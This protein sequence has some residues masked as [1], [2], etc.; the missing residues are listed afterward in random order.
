MRT[1]PLFRLPHLALPPSLP[2][3]RPMSAK[4]D[5]QEGMDFAAELS[6]KE[7]GSS[8]SSS[9]SS[10]SAAAAA[11]AAA[12][13][14]EEELPAFGEWT[15]IV[16]RMAF[17]NTIAGMK[18]SSKEEAKKFI[19]KVA[20]ERKLFKIPPGKKEKTTGAAYSKFIA[21]ISSNSK[22]LPAAARECYVR[23]GGEV[24]SEAPEASQTE[25]SV[26]NISDLVDKIAEVEAE[27]RAL[28]V[29]KAKREEAHSTELAKLKA[30]G[31]AASKSEAEAKAANAKE[32]DRLD[33]ILLRLSKQNASG[34]GSGSKRRS[35]GGGSGGSG[36]SS[37]KKSKSLEAMLTRVRKSE[38]GLAALEVL[39]DKDINGFPA[40]VND[41]VTD[42]PY[43]EDE[44]FDNLKQKVVNE[45]KRE[46][47]D[48]F[49]AFGLV[50]EDSKDE[51][52]EDHEEKEEEEG[53]D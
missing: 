29:A 19:K 11:A 26:A 9:S 32:K 39:E 38:A 47:L 46:F 24:A 31:T 5:S 13:A 4:A 16:D 10:S 40:L 34:G 41:K 28:E 51:D 14:T 35:T 50:M 12:A 25:W 1:L 48:D 8:S 45:V 33:A 22:H 6:P 21:Y 3:R 2:P 36:G 30:A 27:G 53:D 23:L 7:G 20:K 17:F 49:I 18:P 52:D 15:D 37:G 42:Y 43:T 44:L